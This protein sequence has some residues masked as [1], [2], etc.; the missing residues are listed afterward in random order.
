MLEV[1]AAFS[2]HLKYLKLKITGDPLFNVLAL[3]PH[4]I[5]LPHCTST[6]VKLHCADCA[7][8]SLIRS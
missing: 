2:L 4:V 5:L 3:R 8:L 6:E 7:A 1:L